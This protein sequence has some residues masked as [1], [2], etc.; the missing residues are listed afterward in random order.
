MGKISIRTIFWVY[1]KIIDQAVE[2][3]TFSINLNLLNEPM[4]NPDLIKMIKY[5]KEKGIV[6]VH[7]HSHG[8]LLTEKKSIELIYLFDYTSIYL[9]VIRKID[10]TPVIPI[11]FIKK[12]LMKYDN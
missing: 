7:F 12:E 6:D 8:G 9:S 11:D 1:K 3:G 2:L 10:P 5:A 4:T